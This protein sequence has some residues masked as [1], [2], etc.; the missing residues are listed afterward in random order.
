MCPSVSYR[1]LFLPCLF[2]TVKICWSAQDDSLLLSAL[3]M[4]Q[5]WTSWIEGDLFISV[6]A[7]SVKDLRLHNLFLIVSHEGPS[8]EKHQVP[9]NATTTLLAEEQRTDA[10]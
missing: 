1:L 9:F 8:P 6:R 5:T 3:K 10:K 4:A 2:V 7:L